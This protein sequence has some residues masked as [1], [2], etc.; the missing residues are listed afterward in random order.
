MT[1]QWLTSLKESI[2]VLEMESTKFYEKGNSSAGTRARKALQDIK[3]LCQEGR[4][5]IQETKSEPKA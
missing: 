1:P 5:H 2:A 4:T 3:S